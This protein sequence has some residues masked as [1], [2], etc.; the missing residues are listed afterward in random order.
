MT[1]TTLCHSTPSGI[2]VLF[3]DGRREFLPEREA[4][5]DREREVYFYAIRLPTAYRVARHF[6]I[7]PRAV[8]VVLTLRELGG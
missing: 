1:M 6:G 8:R 7:N 2:H 3:A 5:W 4:D